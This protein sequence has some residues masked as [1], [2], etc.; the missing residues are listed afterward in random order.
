MLGVLYSRLHSLGT[1]ALLRHKP[2][3]KNVHRDEPNSNYIQC[4][5]RVAAEVETFDNPTSVSVGFK[6]RTPIIHACNIESR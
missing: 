2:L 1:G 4:V 6:A 5:L 3:Q